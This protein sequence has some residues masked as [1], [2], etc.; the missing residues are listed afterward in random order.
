VLQV[1]IGDGGDCGSIAVRGARMGPIA[2]E[3][4]RNE[5]RRRGEGIVVAGR[6]RE[7]KKMMVGRRMWM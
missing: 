4:G 1:R 7:R 6:R 5:E 3:V 2:V